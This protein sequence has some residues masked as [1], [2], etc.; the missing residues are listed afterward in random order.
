MVD[1][2]RIHVFNNLI[3]KITIIKLGVDLVSKR[4]RFFLL[5]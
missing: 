5:Q 3:Y 1:Y 4:R 2:I